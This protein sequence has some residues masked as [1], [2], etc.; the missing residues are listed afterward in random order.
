MSTTV[1]VNGYARGREGVDV[2]QHGPRGH[3]ELSGQLVG[4]HPASLARDAA[5]GARVAARVHAV[6]HASFAQDLD[7]IVGEAGEHLRRVAAADE[8]RLE[9]L[10]RMLARWGHAAVDADVRART[11]YLTQIGYISM[12]AQ[13]NMETRIARIPTYVGIYTGEDPEPREMA[14]FAA[15]LRAN[16]PT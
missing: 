15:R 14:R 8:T 6:D 10:R 2:T 3:F 7:I 1:G 11:I 12:R 4:G 9:A 13:E 5:P 16:P